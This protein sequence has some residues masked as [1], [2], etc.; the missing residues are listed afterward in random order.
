MKFRNETGS[1]KTFSIPMPNG[2]VRWISADP[3][4]V[5]DVPDEHAQIA[6]AFGLTNLSK[7][8]PKPVVIPV[9]AP[10]PKKPTK[11]ELFKLNDAAQEK[12]LKALG[13]KKIPHLEKDRIALILKLQ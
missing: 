3:N 2:T 7:P 12:I 13:V 8:K 10:K 6:E 9:L 5:V 1:F 4:N 11:E